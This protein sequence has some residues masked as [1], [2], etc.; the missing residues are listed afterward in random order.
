MSDLYPAA[1]DTT[2]AQPT[3]HQKWRHRW[4]LIGWLTVL[5]AILAWC[6][7]NAAFAVSF[8]EQRAKSVSEGTAWQTDPVTLTMNMMTYGSTVTIP[9]QDPILADPNTVF[10]AAVLDYS[11]T[12]TT[13]DIACGMTLVGD[14]RQWRPTSSLLID[15]LVPDIVSGCRTIDNDGNPIT[16]GQMG[17][18]F[19]IP[20]SAVPEIRGVEMTVAIV[21]LS[22]NWS[23]LY[24]HRTWI[25]VLEGT[26][27]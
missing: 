20:R 3:R 10:V 12:N 24:K 14:G 23:S 25:A 22:N 17:A 15:Q 27:E 19:E 13:D 1:P 9:G 18:V 7:A 4:T 11:L 21:D 8:E 6:V 26:V 16:G 5:V 2:A